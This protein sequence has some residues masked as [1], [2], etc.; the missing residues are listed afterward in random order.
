MHQLEIDKNKYQYINKALTP[1]GSYGARFALLFPCHNGLRRANPVLMEFQS[2]LPAN[3]VTSL[4]GNKF[5]SY[6][7]I[8]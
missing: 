5:T 2:M 1:F 6:S 7:L 8:H 4:C 3:T